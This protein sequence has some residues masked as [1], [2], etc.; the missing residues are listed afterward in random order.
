MES[1]NL[2]LDYV[3]QCITDSEEILKRYP[4]SIGLKLNLESMKAFRAEAVK[5]LEIRK[6]CKWGCVNND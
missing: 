5:E 6:T 2:D 3:D 4:N 1:M